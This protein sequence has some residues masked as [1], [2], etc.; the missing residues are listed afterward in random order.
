MSAYHPRTFIGNPATCDH[1][2]GG[3]KFCKDNGGELVW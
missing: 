2:H 1:G 3:N